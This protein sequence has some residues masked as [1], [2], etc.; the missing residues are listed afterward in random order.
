M[1][2][3]ISAIPLVMLPPEVTDEILNQSYAAIKTTGAYMQVSYSL[4]LQKRLK[5]LYPSIRHKMILFNVP[6]A[7]VYTCRKNAN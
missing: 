6:P 7:F 2:L 5:Q 4:M 3:V 1:D